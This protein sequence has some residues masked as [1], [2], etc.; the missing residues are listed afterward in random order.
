MSYGVCSINQ[1]V[2]TLEKVLK[3]KKDTGTGVMFLDEA[4]K[5]SPLAYW[6]FE[7]NGNEPKKLLENNP[8]AT[9]WTSLGRSL[10]KCAKDASKGNQTFRTCSERLS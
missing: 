4:M 1:Q 9:F 10:E 3:L 8:T 2:Y 6:V 5:V 7:S